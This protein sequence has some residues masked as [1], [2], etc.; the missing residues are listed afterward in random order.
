[1]IIFNNFN[2]GGKSLKALFLVVLASVFPVFA[3]E[4]GTPQPVTPESAAG[5]SGIDTEAAEGGQGGEQAEPEKPEPTPEELAAQKEKED[6]EKLIE[7]D[8]KT[9]TLSEL[10]EWAREL[11]LGEGGGRGELESRIRQHYKVN[12][13]ASK[14][15]DRVISIESARTTEYFTL[16]EVDEEYARLSGGVVISLKDGE[17]L[18]RIEAWEILFN[19]TRNIV[20][21]TGGVKYRKEEGGAIET[22]SG[23][24][25]IVNLDTWVGSF[26]DTVSE[27]AMTGGDTAYRFAGQVISKTDSETTVL[28]KATVSNAQSEE[29]FWSL[30]ASKIWLFPGSDWAMFNAILKVGEIPV[31][32]FPFFAY[33]ADEVI[34]HP[35][36]GAR[37][38]SGYYVQTTTYIIGRPTADPAKANSISK[39]LGS[40]DGMQKQRQGL[41]LRSSGKP[42]TRSN[43]TNLSILFDSYTNLGF[44][45][46]VESN[47]AKA[48]IFNNLKL[49]VGF[50][51]TR[52]LYN[53]YGFYTPYI[54]DDDI[55]ESSWDHS[56]LFGAEVPFRYRFNI[57]SGTSGRYG[58]IDFKFPLYS[59]PTINRD[60]IQNR[61]EQMDYLQLLTSNNSDDVELNLNSTN[62]GSYQWVLNMRPNVSTNFFAPWVSNISVNTIS[63]SLSF[64]T[65]T[66]QKP[67]IHPFAEPPSSQFFIPDKYTIYT[68]S[69]S[70]SGSPFAGTT[71]TKTAEEHKNPLA[72]IGDPVSPWIKENEEAAAKAAAPSANADTLKVPV[73]S[74]SWT[75][76]Q[77]NL[78]RFSMGYN[79][80]P[81]SA[82]EAQYYT[83]S[84]LTATAANYKTAED[85][86]WGDFESILSNFR[87]DGSL[88]MTL[89]EAHNNLFSTTL[90]FS[91]SYQWQ[92]HVYYSDKLTVAEKRPLNLADYRGRQWT[93]N[94]NY[95][96]TLNPFYWAPMWKSTNFQYS[97]GGL[98]MRSLFDEQ[99]YNA[100]MQTNLGNPNYEAS[101]E[102]KIDKIAWTRDYINTHRLAANLGVNVMDKMQN[103]TLSMELPP[104]YELYSGN[105]T[106][107]AWRFESNA[108]MQIQ[109]DTDENKAAAITNSA[110]KYRYVSG[111]LFRPLY[112]T[113]S[114][115]IG[116][117][118][119]ARFYAVWDPE[120]SEWT[121]MSAN[122]TWGTFNMSY[123]A[124]YMYKYYYDP[125]PGSQGWKQETAA[126]GGQQ[127]LYPRDFSINWG[128]SYK[129]PPFFHEL[130]NFTVTAH[131]ALTIDLQR[132]TYSKFSFTLSLTLGITKFLDFTMSANSENA[133]IYRYIQNWQMFDSLDVEV[134]QGKENNFLLDLVNS[135]RFDNE[136]LRRN[137]G[138]KLR[139]FSF[140]AVHHLGD[141]DATL[142]V[143]LSPYLDN[144][145]TNQTDWQYRFRTTFSFYVQ[146]LPI[147]EIQAG[148]N[149]ENEK[150]IKRETTN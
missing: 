33:P 7:L 22:F 50:G 53:Y 29:P 8:L 40:G 99:K 110:I 26:I 48:F 37:T 87:T 131:S 149:Y 139:S 32:Y 70:L 51:W 61:S 123:N 20:S 27:R 49:S 85:I 5:E 124:A 59:D 86:D 54:L 112:L 115:A 12:Q 122:F 147:T 76:P 21:A 13:P 25:I 92:N 44:Y 98:V 72:G 73:L 100:D 80:T 111:Y 18:H 105:M 2:M 134:G 90:G 45:T 148:M 95:N 108:N 130:M 68:L 3:Q 19:R 83:R 127:K 23:D 66:N 16:K 63:T 140:S 31:F 17:A 93:I 34:F 81:S 88:N 35:V 30:K 94:S 135:F 103:L 137:S 101:P 15:W 125:T 39:I 71:Q 91:G 126:G 120:L 67:R 11:G 121:N 97:M 65:A 104:R 138:Y 62:I 106:I 77:S 143:S 129:S 96:F 117:G 84:F 28:K 75:L 119:S 113:E 52:T 150:F 82:T 57:E 144:T 132:Y 42:E 79:F 6:Q 107:R 141:W 118:K 146:W 102:W 133:E 10:A 24:S 4:N 1:M 69:A 56:W 136:K 46:G 74:Q 64:I 128:P 41:F 43:D 47:F 55:W 38:R 109:E 145:A 142:R 116:T 14:N 78:L 58:S 36:L 114:L 89:N 60:T 9:A